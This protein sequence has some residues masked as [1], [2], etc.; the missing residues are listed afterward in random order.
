MRNSRLFL[1]LPAAAPG[2]DPGG[3]AAPPRVP[4]LGG[5]DLAERALGEIVGVGR[6]DEGHAVPQLPRGHVAPEELAVVAPALARGLDPLQLRATG[7]H[8]LAIAAAGRDPALA[9]AFVRVT[10]LVDRPEALPD[11]LAGVV[12]CTPSGAT[13]EACMR[14]FVESFGLRAFRRPLT[15]A[16]IWGAG[17]GHMRLDGGLLWTPLI[18]VVASLTLL[19]LLG[20][21]AGAA[22][23]AP[24]GKPTTTTSVRSEVERSRVTLIVV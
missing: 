7:D 14:S 16:K 8:G 11:R 2:Q 24:G 18:I 22:S 21:G 23:A 3:H 20:L 5:E 12:G 19:S 15:T 17:L 9:R 10:G 4:R 13:D 6:R 1:I